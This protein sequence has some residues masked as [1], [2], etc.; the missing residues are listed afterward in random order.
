MA[1]L[2][3]ASCLAFAGQSE[4]AIAR[5]GVFILDTQLMTSN[6][7]STSRRRQSRR[8]LLSHAK[9]LLGRQFGRQPRIPSQFPPIVVRMQ[10]STVDL[11]FR[12]SREFV[13]VLLRGWN[14]RRLV[15]GFPSSKEEQQA[16]A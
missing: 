2:T 16:D 12:L 7:D 1:V 15:L 10:F 4:S 3:T 13:R 9:I 11:V 5:E 6:I 8:Q 14:V